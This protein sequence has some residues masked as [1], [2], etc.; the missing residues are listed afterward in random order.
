[1]YSD[2]YTTPCLRERVF[3]TDGTTRNATFLE[4]TVILLKQFVV[5]DET[6]SEN[7]KAD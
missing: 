3:L 5:L 2:K 6:I 1:M 4:A 7:A